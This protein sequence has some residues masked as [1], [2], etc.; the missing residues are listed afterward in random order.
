MKIAI[1]Q[2][3]LKQIEAITKALDH[4]GH[5]VVVFSNWTV[6]DSE[7]LNFDLI[8]LNFDESLIK[9]IRIN[10]GFTLPLITWLENENLISDALLSGG[11][12]YLIDGEDI[13]ELNHR[14]KPY[15][16]RD[17]SDISNI[18]LAESNTIKLDEG[19]VQLSKEEFRLSHFLYSHLN[20]PL[21]KKHL[22]I[23]VWGVDYINHVSDFDQ[24]VS[25]VKSK[26]VGTLNACKLR[27]ME[28]KGYGYRLIEDTTS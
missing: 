11:T 7:L 24:V 22:M 14:I 1:L 19:E 27:L 15:I 21:K 3:N 4:A 16:V 2:N 9:N 18:F 5:A 23:K 26:L 17:Y 10:Y 6:L 25:G 8:I 13:S 28:I 20:R 12:D